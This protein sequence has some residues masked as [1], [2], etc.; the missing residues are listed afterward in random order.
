V[1]TRGKKNTALEI[2]APRLNALNQLDKHRQKLG[3]WLA[4]TA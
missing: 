3:F 2:E 1:N 4:Q